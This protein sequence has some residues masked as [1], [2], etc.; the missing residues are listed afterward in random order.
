MSS[1][2][3]NWVFNFSSDWAFSSEWFNFMS[4]DFLNLNIGS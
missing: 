1:D 3:L 2:F 4:S